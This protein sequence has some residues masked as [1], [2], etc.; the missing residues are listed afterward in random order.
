VAAIEARPLGPSEFRIWEYRVP[1]P[2]F[3]V[4][5]IVNFAGS[6]TLSEWYR[7]A[8]LRDR[9]IESVPRRSWRYAIL[10]K[11]DTTGEHAKMWREFEPGDRIDVLRETTVIERLAK[12][13]P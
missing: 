7:R 12:D 5:F 2:G 6:S 11:G 13:T 4:G 9:V 10:R 8:D 3:A 1:A